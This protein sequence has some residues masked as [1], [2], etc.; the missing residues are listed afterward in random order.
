M[1]H[2]I[3]DKTS[4]EQMAE[5]LEELENYVKLAVDVR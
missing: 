4:A 5:M 3:G 1:I 2:I